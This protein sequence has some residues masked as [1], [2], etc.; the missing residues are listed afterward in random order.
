MA[1]RNEVEPK[2]RQLCDFDSVLLRS[3]TQ[4]HHTNNIKR[5]LSATKWSRSPVSRVISTPCYCAQS[6]NNSNKRWLSATKWSRSPVRAQQSGVEA[7]IPNAQSPLSF[8]LFIKSSN[9]EVTPSSSKNW[10]IPLI[11]SKFCFLNLPFNPFSA[12]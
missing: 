10:S 7:P 6:P 4:Q 5:W 12:S 3:I 9:S 2:P 11:S 1:E 8:L